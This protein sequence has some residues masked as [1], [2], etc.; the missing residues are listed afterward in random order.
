VQ[1]E[2]QRRAPR[3]DARVVVLGREHALPLHP[4]LRKGLGAL[5]RLAAQQV[6]HAAQEAVERPPERRHLGG[7]VLPPLAQGPAEEQRA[8]QRHA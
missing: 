8:Q 2:E 4:G 1:R 5:A 3:G 7:V 6:E